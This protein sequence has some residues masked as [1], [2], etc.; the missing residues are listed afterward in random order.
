MMFA[1]SDG[2]LAALRVTQLG[3]L[4]TSYS[5]SPD[6][7]TVAFQSM[8]GAGNRVFVE[9]ADGSDRHPVANGLLSGW[10]AGGWL[11]LFTG[12]FGEFSPGSYV[13]LDSRSGRQR[14]VLSSRQVAVY[15]HARVAGFGDVAYSAD[16]RYLAIRALL[17]GFRGAA[18][19]PL[20]A[21]RVIVIARSDGSI[22]RVITSTVII[23]M[24]AWS[25]HGHQLA[26]TTSGFPVPHELYVLRSPRAR[27]WRV[28]SQA[29]HF[30]WVTWSPDDRW[31]L[32]DNQHQHAW[33]LLR[34]T[35]HRQAASMVGA[36]VPTRRLPRLGGTPLWC[37][38][39]NHYGGA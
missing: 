18:K 29:D 39:Q 12:G 35:G 30:D 37:C 9:R 10:S 17:A 34:L 6:G 5:W 21:E 4:N 24:F 23:S 16:G 3:P 20:G 26:Y 25:P 13:T 8:S 2:R 15:A 19:L 1:L 38:P 31:L 36:S 28:L 7:R 11:V 27:P 22:V 32:I 33:T 14:P